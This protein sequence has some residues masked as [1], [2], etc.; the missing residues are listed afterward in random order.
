MI[1]TLSEY[2]KIRLATLKEVLGEAIANGSADR[3][4]I[5]ISLTH[6]IKALTGIDL[7]QETTDY[8]SPFHEETMAGLDRLKIDHSGDTNDKVLGNSVHLK[9]PSENSGQKKEE[10]DKLWYYCKYCRKLVERVSD[11]KSIGSYCKG[12]RR[13]THLIKTPTNSTPKPQE[14]K[15]EKEGWEDSLDNLLMKGRSDD[16]TGGYD[17][18]KDNLKQLIRTTIKQ[19]KL[20]LIEKIIREVIGEDDDGNGQ[21]HWGWRN[22]LRAE[23]KQK[24]CE[25]EEKIK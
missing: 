15:G 8:Q 5:I 20:A 22:R 23:Q 6:K 2:N 12:T 21:D 16:D 11:K 9:Q 10:P 4:S 7:P 18:N 3:Q 17:F 1:P 25:L 19:E 14:P 13:N 24:L